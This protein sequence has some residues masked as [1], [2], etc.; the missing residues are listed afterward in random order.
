VSIERL[1]GE[2]EGGQKVA[3]VTGQQ[4]CRTYCCGPGSIT[5]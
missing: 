3:Q 2:G 5:R 1:A 4:R